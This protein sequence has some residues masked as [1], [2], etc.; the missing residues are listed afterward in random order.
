MSEAKPGRPTK[1]D[2]AF[3]DQ[4]VAFCAEGYSIKAFAGSI[5]VARSTINEWASANPE[6]SEALSRAKAAST[7]WWEGAARKIALGGDGNASMAIFGLKNMG[8][9]DWAE[10]SKTEHSGAVRFE[11]VKVDTGIGG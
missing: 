8:D 3:C 1:Y 10:T 11:T 2:P 4:I 5:G 7:L 9:E 6:F